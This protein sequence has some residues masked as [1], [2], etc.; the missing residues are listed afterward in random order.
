M[1]ILTLQ[2]IKMNSRI[3]GDEEDELLAELGEEAEQMVLNATRCTLDQIYGE[4]G[5]VPLPLRRAMLMIVDYL[6]NNRG[7]DKPMPLAV[8]VMI[9]PY[10]RFNN[11][12]GRCDV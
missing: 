8:S 4:H 2:Q 11:K 12:G 3:D 10:V 6:Y 1:E 9:R 7:E 5:F